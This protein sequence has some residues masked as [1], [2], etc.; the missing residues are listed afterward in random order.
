MNRLKKWIKNTTT[1]EL[2]KYKKIAIIKGQ[3]GYAK[4]LETGSI[5]INYHDKCPLC[6]G[7][8]YYDPKK[9]DYYCPCCNPIPD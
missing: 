6:G 9:K 7:D 8:M 4:F 2:N 1:I 3:C 5:N